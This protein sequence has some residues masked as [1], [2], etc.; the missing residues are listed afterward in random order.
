[1]VF[2]LKEAVNRRLI[3]NVSCIEFVGQPAVQGVT[4]RDLKINKRGDI[5]KQILRFCFFSISAP[6][7]QLMCSE[8]QT[9]VII[10]CTN[11][12]NNT[13]VDIFC[14]QRYSGALTVASAILSWQHR[15]GHYI[16]IKNIYIKIYSLCHVEL[17]HITN[18][19]IHICS[20][21]SHMNALISEIITLFYKLFV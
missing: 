5:Q 13:T 2:P 9:F 1:M 7:L 14:A 6:Q 20:Y 17:G 8:L 15:A 10:F 4:H 18:I 19:N 16:S 3:R 12:C 21:D 11:N